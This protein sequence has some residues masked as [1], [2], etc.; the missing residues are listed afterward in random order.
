MW[1]L[2]AQPQMALTFEENKILYFYNQA[3]NLS[4]G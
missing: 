4:Q 2:L 1:L 3:V